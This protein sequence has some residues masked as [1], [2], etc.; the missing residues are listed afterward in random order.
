MSSKKPSKQKIS[1]SPLSPE[2][3]GSFERLF[4]PRGA[5]AGCWCMWWRLPRAEFVRGQGD[6]NRRAMCKLVSSGIVPGILAYAN[7]EAV[8]WCAI[9]PR[10][11]YSRL[12]RSRI[13]QPVDEK[14]VWSI[15]CLF[16]AKAYRRT[17]LTARLLRATVAWAR[18]QGARIVEAYPIEP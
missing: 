6:G 12:A 7:D 10:D 5:C 11:A 2:H 9:G 15:T 16:V 4:G 1:F 14:P 3:W 8:G 13:L 17:G 18:Q